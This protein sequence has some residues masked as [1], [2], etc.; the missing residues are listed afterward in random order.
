MKKSQKKK[1]KKIKE[2]PVVLVSFILLCRKSI[3][4]KTTQEKGSFLLTDPGLVTSHPHSRTERNKRMCA[5]SSASFSYSYTAQDPKSRTSVTHFQARS[6]HTNLGSQEKFTRTQTCPEANLINIIP[7]WNSS[8]V[9]LGYI[10]LAIKL[11]QMFKH[12]QIYKLKE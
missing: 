12:L 6:F 4:T 10:K 1:K 8:Q 2:K 11:L 5:W 3:L 9:H 7:Y